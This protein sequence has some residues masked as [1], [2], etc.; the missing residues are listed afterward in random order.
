MQT[1]NLTPKLQ[2]SNQTSRLS[3]VGFEQ[4]PGPVAQLLGLAKSIY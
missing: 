1:E 4:L 2:N 3:W